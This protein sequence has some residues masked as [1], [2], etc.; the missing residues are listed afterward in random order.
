MWLA[1]LCKHVRGVH[2]NVCSVP[3]GQLSQQH[4]AGWQKRDRTPSEITEPCHAW[5]NTT[6]N[7]HT[8]TP[9]AVCVSP[10][11]TLSDACEPV[12]LTAC[13][14]TGHISCLFLLPLWVC[15]IFQKH[16]SST[17]TFIVWLLLFHFL[18]FL[19]VHYMCLSSLFLNHLTLLSSC[20]QMAN[21]LFQEVFPVWRLSSMLCRQIPHHC[22]LSF[23]VS[24][25][26]RHVMQMSL[27][28]DFFSMNWKS[29]QSCGTRRLT[30]PNLHILK[31]CHNVLLQ[32]TT[33]NCVYNECSTQVF[34]MTVW[35]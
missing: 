11:C 17:H 2:I 35:L 19:S 31:P 23:T 34:S 14:W 20:S 4:Q 26:L 6:H 13:H 24:G 32:I 21:R 29:E 28:F 30:H 15:H 33:L 3:G 8:H 27:C 16:W 18:T 5:V 25:P 1:T 9:D 10:Q 7:T 22:L 12:C